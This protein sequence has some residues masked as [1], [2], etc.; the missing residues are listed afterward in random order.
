MPLVNS[1]TA[2][3]GYIKS[4][5]ALGPVNTPHGTVYAVDTAEIDRLLVGI[6]GD[7]APSSAQVAKDSAKA[8]ADADAKA[9]KDAEDLEKLKVQLRKQIKDELHKE[10]LL[11][12]EADQ[13]ATITELKAE[14]TP[15]VA[16]EVAAE[17]PVPT[18]PIPPSAVEKLAPVKQQPE[19]KTTTP[20]KK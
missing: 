5:K 11:K 3:V 16:A 13:S 20:P 10:A 18:R 4:V 2:L 1:A 14:L 6:E 8:K 9:A 17:P 12:A 19:P 7:L 15:Q